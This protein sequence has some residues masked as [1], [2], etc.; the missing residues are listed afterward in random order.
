MSRL[1]TYDPARTFDA[2]ALTGSYQDVGAVLATPAYGYVI[3]NTSDVD[4]QVSFNDGS[5]NGPIIP[6][7]GT[8][9]DSVYNQGL[10]GE[11]AIRVLPEGA[12]IQVKQVTGA[13]TDG[14][15]IVNIVRE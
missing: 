13:G 5:T 4:M 14:D 6:A 3:F 12:Q 1:P 15:L 2:T 7:G 10:R 11:N 9:S 8:M